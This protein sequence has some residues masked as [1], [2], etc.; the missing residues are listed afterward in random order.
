MELSGERFGALGAKPGEGRAGAV[1]CEFRPSGTRHERGSKAGHACDRACRAAAGCASRHQFV[2]RTPRQPAAERQ[3]QRRAAKPK[4]RG[5]GNGAA[6]LDTGHF[7][8]Q[9]FQGLVESGHGQDR[10]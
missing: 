4:R 3:V 6:P 9:L 10:T 2:K 7:A 8:S 5:H 1:V